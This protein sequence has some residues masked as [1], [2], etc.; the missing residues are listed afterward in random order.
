[1][2]RRRAALADIPHRGGAEMPITLSTDWSPKQAVAVFE[3]PGELR[4]RVWVQYGLQIQ[5]VF[6]C[7]QRTAAPDA[8]DD[9]D[10]ADVPF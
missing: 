5:Q 9:I 2:K 3:L 1:M 6:R 4:E 10:E 7:Q 8:T